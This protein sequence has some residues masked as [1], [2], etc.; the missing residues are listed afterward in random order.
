MRDEASVL[1]EVCVDSTEGALAAQEGGAQR[2]ELCSALFEGGLTPSAG[3]I[4]VAR[5]HV[6]I[7]LNVIIRP[8]SGDFLYSDAEM[9]LMTEDIRVAKRL[10]AD[11]VVIGVLDSDGRV[12]VDRTARLIAEARPL[13]VT[14][15]RAFDMT[16]DPFEALEQL[17]RLRV[18]RV[19]TSGQESTA[20]AGIDL[21]RDLVSAAG[22]RMTVMPGG[23]IQ[24]RNIQK[25]VH[26][27]GARELHVTGFQTVG[28]PM[29]FR[30][31][32]VFMGGE[33]RPPEYDRMVTDAERIR[34]L[35][36]RVQ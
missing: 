27:T 36:R 34:K 12:D 21:L 18:D 26:L 28:S 24:E 22:E 7:G 15:H 25:I 4:S 19:L 5:E 8:R 2:V 11:G 32:R 35:V 13:S 3:A 9:E 30:N 14:F 17:I 16:R 29:R 33:L 31:E 6:R 1:I 20:L 23:D 10:G